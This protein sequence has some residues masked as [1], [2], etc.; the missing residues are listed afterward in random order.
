V[1]NHTLVLKCTMMQFV[2]LQM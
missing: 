1:Y 2:C